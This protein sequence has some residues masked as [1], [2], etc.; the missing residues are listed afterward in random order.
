MGLYPFNPKVSQAIQTS[1]HGMILDRGFISHLLCTPVALDADGYVASTNMKVGAY[2]LAAVSP[3]DD[4]AH[5]VTLVRTVAGAADTPGTVVVVGTDLAGDAIS[6][7]LTPGANGV[8]VVG[9]KAFA[10]IT[11]IT[12]VDWSVSEANDTIVVGWGDVLG[13]PDYLDHNTVLAAYL[14]SV[15]EATAP[16]VVASATILSN[17]TIDLNSA[18]DGSAVD[19]YY[20]S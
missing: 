18:L 12:G 14:N 17:N 8:T 7:T 16:T 20:I 3:D 11:S 13:L 4:C 19:V 15:R 2:T 1:V 10:T 6:E 5:N 9:A